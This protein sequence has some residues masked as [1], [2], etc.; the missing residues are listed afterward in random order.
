MEE[1]AE[2]NHNAAARKKGTYFQALFRRL[3]PRLG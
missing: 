3:L 1:S 2:E